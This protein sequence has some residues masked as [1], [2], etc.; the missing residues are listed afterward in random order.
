MVWSHKSEAVW[1]L[2]NMDATWFQHAWRR[3]YLRAV[4]TFLDRYIASSN[5]FYA[6]GLASLSRP[7]RSCLTSNA[8]DL[9]RFLSRF[10]LIIHVW[11]RHAA[12]VS[13]SDLNGWRAATKLDK[14]VGFF[15]LFFL[16]LNQDK[17][18]WHMW[19]FE[20]FRAF[21]RCVIII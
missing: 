14:R 2:V 7:V 18:H 4:N 6:Q 11:N 9:I 15:F 19:S 10:G 5:T 13:H 3:L 20:S 17:E 1:K 21:G 8:L 16:L 12:Y